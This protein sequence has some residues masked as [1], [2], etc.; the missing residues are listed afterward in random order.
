LLAGAQASRRLVIL[1]LG[2]E[3][4]KA[5]KA[6]C[7]GSALPN[8]PKAV[9][10]ADEAY[11]LGDSVLAAK[12]GV[13][14][15]G[16]QKDVEAALSG[17]AKP[18]SPSVTLKGDEKLVFQ[19]AMPETQVAV[20]GA[21]RVSPEHFRL[22][23]EAEVPSDAVADMA[24]GKLKQF[25]E[26]ASVLQQNQPD[27]P[28]GKL[29]SALQVERK[30]RH[31]SAA[32]EL[33]EPVIDQARDLG[34]LIGLSVYGARRYMQNSKAAEARAVMAQIARNYAATLKNPPEKGVRPLKK[35]VSLP[36]VPAE[37]PRGARYQSAGSDWK[38]W[39]VIQFG[40]SEPQY[41]QFEV[42]AAKDGK[43]AEIF[44]RGDLN[45][46]GKTSLFSIKVQLDPK[47]RD[48]TAI[49]HQERDPLE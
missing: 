6:A 41:Y 13:V 14:L 9:A 46:D 31:F 43:T 42:V 47:T 17:P 49:D 3:G 12:A 44:A 28:L 25:R 27:V 21:L 26:Q 11:A 5:V 39:S 20:K 37:V 30:G 23:T 10:G 8:L 22:E 40:L 24:E 1:E 45:G 35:L 33:R 34:V 38:P 29:M 2:A 4:L 48:L 36:P 32:F 7:L 18:L 19:L 15:I 16:P